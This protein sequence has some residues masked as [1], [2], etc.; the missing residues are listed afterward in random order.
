LGLRVLVDL[1]VILRVRV[2]VRVLV[3]ELSVSLGAA[4]VPETGPNALA[5]NATRRPRD[6][7]AQP[8]EAL[9]RFGPGE[10]RPCRLAV[11]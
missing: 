4:V 2:R 1:R 6:I 9:A 5:H 8:S 3:L 7:Q 11:C 10:G